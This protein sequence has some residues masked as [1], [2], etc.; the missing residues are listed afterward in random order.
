MKFTLN[1][2]CLYNILYCLDLKDLITCSHVC[3]MF[4]QST[5]NEMLWQKLC[6]FDIICHQKYYKTFKKYYQFDQFLFKYT[7]KSF[8]DTLKL[9][10]INLRYKNLKTLPTTLFQCQQLQELYLTRNQLTTLPS[11]IGQC[12][13]LQGLYLSGNQLTTLPTTL[14]QC[15]QLRHLHLNGNQ[16]TTLPS[17]ISQCQQLR[18]LDL[19]GNKLT[20]LPTILF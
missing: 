15:Q 6:K 5:C 2:D 17:E 1:N 19:S 9:T 4:L 11:E 14:F 10:T 3:K 16:L 20:T 7:N 8:N 18:T 12:Q 13:Q